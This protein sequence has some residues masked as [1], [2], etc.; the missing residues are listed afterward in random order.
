MTVAFESVNYDWGSNTKEPKNFNKNFY[1]KT[2]SP[3]SV[4]GNGSSTIFG[5]YGVL[6]GAADVLGTLGS[7][8]II[9]A[10]IKGVTLARNASKINKASLKSEATNVIN[11]ALGN[12]SVT[13]N[14]ANGVGSAIQTGTLKAEPSKLTGK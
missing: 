10:A 11:S 2:P 8:N 14:Q 3:L 9:G 4:G 12:L 1:D 5:Q 13:G 7:G 6:S